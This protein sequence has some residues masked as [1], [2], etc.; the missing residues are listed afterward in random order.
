[1][2]RRVFLL[3]AALVAILMMALP[4]SAEDRIYADRDRVNIYEKADTDSKIISSLRGGQSCIVDHYNRNNSN[5]AYIWDPTYRGDGQRYGWVHMTSMSYTMPQRY[6]DHEWSD[7][8]IINE[9]TCTDV[10]RKSRYCHICGLGQYKETPALGHEWGDWNIQSEPTCTEDGLRTRTCWRC[11]W[12]DSQTIDRLGHKYGDWKTIKEATCTS[13]GK[14]KRTCQR[15]GHEDVQTTDKLPHSYGEWTIVRE[16]TCSREGERKHTCKVCGHVASESIEKLPHQFEWKIIKECTDHSS[17][18]RSQVCKV[19]GYTEDQVS[20]DP[21]G[22]LR[23]GD[24]SEAVREVQQL[25]A[26]QNYLNADGADG[27]FGGGTEKAIMNFQEAQGFTAD[28]VAWPQTINKLRHDFGPWTVITP[29]TRTTAGERK[30]VCKDCGFEQHE[31]IKPEPHLEY[32]DRGENVRAIQQII[33]S[34]GFDAGAFDGIYGHKLD[35]AYINFSQANGISFEPG[36]VNADQIDA[37]VSYWTKQLPD[38]E[39][40]GEG[41]ADTPVDPALTITRVD[42][43][44]D[45][46]IRTY[47]WSITN[48]GSERCMFAA[49]LL[50]YGDKPDFRSDTIT[51]VIDGTEL[52]EFCDG[53]ASGKFEVSAEMGEGKLNFCALTVSESSGAKWLSNCITEEGFAK[54][55]PETAAASG[56]ESAAESIAEAA[57]ES[58][59][60]EVTHN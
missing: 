7:W 22:T 11:G 1:M 51:L 2:K 5:W 19:C 52:R 49:L 60:V 27:I 45:D 38:D 10:G 47:T 55:Q 33:S 29:L 36:H 3:A 25:L 37:L 31:I 58:G 42:Q 57:P 46:D 12:R 39:W 53:S 16:P 18:I 13:E 59:V 44:S 34:V 20:Y 30:R 40:R 4:A 43:D 15:C 35:D 14:R 28:G 9:A 26:D 50:S 21:E 32:G 8:E 54:P 56:V 24:R 6:C 17:G 48:M 41:S 23:R